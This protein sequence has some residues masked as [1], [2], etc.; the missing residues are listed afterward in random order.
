MQRHCVGSGH[1]GWWPDLSLHWHLE[2]IWWKGKKLSVYMLSVQ[3][4]LSCLLKK[5]G[6]F[7]VLWPNNFCTS[8]ENKAEIGGEGPGAKGWIV[9]T[10]WK[11]LCPRQVDA[12]TG[13]HLFVPDATILR[14]ITNELHHHK[15]NFRTHIE[16]VGRLT[17]FSVFYSTQ[18]GFFV[19]MFQIWC[20][21]SCM[22]G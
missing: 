5:N 21:N 19:W 7:V 3:S 20:L 17:F 13:K 16:D 9:C 1:L 10:C 6:S 2:F 4:V 15:L 14:E 12:W 18:K 22:A 8:W 11:F